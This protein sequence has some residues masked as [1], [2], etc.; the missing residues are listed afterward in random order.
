MR[1][2]GLA[3]I[4]FALTGCRA[5]YMDV[6]GRIAQRASEAVDVMPSSLPARELPEKLP[7]PKKAAGGIRQAL[8]GAPILE[9]ESPWVEEEQE[10]PQPPDKDKGKKIMPFIDKLKFKEGILG[11]SVPD[12]VL[13]PFDA[14]EKERLKKIKEQFPELP[15]PPL[16]PEAP[17]GPQGVPMTLAELQQI[18]LRNNPLIRQ[19]H[20]DIQ[21]ARGQALQV[22]L[23][24]NPSIGYEASTAGQGSQ[25]GV[26]TPGQQ[27]G[28]VQQDIITM[29]KL[30]IAREAAQREVAIAEQ[31]LKAA[32]TDVQTQVRTQYF[33]VL[34]ARENHRVVKGLTDLTDELYNV[35]L[36]QMIAGEVAAYE[37]MQIRVLAM[38]SRT[39]LVLAHNRYVAAWKQ[40]AAS[41]GTPTMPLTALAGK[42]DMPVPHLEHDRILAYV[43][44][45]H[46]DVLAARIGVDKM[47][48]L[49]RLAEVQPYPDVTFHVAIQKDYTTPPF[50]TVANVNVGVPFPL[51]N[52]NQG[53]IQAV[54]AQTDR[55]VAEQAR[56]HNDLTSRVAEAFQ[57]YENN[58]LLLQMYRQ[59]MLP[60]QVQAFRAA[61]AR[62]AAVGDKNVSYNDIVT[63]QQALAGLINSYLVVLNDQWVSVV[64]IGNLTQTR[65]L[66][67]THPLDEV[68]PV[69][70]VF[71]IVR[72][73]LR[74]RRQTPLER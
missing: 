68:A 29:G 19:A 34:S 70:D 41:L 3:T 30:S 67:Q 50:G 9:G 33:A 13:P 28:F 57:R 7:E 23:Y 66:F 58:R 61:V 24:P 11:F 1:W 6:D 69:P 22:G 49:T 46:S 48:Y 8:I 31:K 20:Q 59:Q 5:F 4:L 36:L 39:N 26:R 44:A 63:V 21:A 51:W 52:R 60:Q 38:Q 25:T 73:H 74:H 72:P 53:A 62:H 65:D 14:P 12:L 37:P 47:R 27:G 64:D 42:I 56:V 71:E 2:L 45:N 32:E 10:Q 16:L 40:L 43:L 15:K 35:L 55:A 17:P 18:A 54:R